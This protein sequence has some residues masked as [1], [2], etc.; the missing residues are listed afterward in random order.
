MAAMLLV[1]RLL[2]FL[3]QILERGSGE[4][5]EMEGPILVPIALSFLL[6]GLARENGG[7]WG[8]RIFELIRFFLIG[9]LEQRIPKRKSKTER[10]S[11]T[12]FWNVVTAYMKTGSPR[13]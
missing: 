3:S 2:R 12:F 7:L 6:A 5:V 10:L 9:C 4:P 8:H 1:T 13:I 11:H